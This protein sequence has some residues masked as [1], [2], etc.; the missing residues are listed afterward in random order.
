MKRA[1]LLLAAFAAGC[2]TPDGDASDASADAIVGGQSD[3]D[4]LSSVVAVISP[5]KPS[6]IC[7]G[8]II[9]PRVVLTAGHCVKG[10]NADKTGWTFQVF[11]GPDRNHR[12]DKDRVI[13]V[14]AFHYPETYDSPGPDSYIDGDI[15][16][17]I[18]AEPTTLSP[19]RWNRKPLVEFDP[20]AEE[21]KPDSL[22]GKIVRVVGYG[23]TDEDDESSNGRRKT[24]SVTVNGVSSGAVEFE[25]GANSPSHGDSGG[26]MLVDEDGAPTII[27]VGHQSYGADFGGNYNR[28]DVYAD[29]IQKQLDAAK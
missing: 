29:F 15:A 28:T 16:V 17:L 3:D 13:D 22:K 2:T 27:G 1:L 14:Q 18:L 5:N 25:G 8:S 24:A 23:R 7:S 20:I 19:M 6:W 12:T 9:A 11:I 10:G 21:A 26:P 4:P